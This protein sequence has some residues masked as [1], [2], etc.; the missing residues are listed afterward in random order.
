[1]GHG[2]SCCLDLTTIRRTP[3]RAPGAGAASSDARGLSTASRSSPVSASEPVPIR[4]VRAPDPGTD[5]GARE[6]GS[7]PGRG[8]DV[9]SPGLM[10]RIHRGDRKAMDTLVAEYWDRLVAFTAGMNGSTESAED[11]VQGVFLRIWEGRGEWTPTDRL[12]GLLYRMTRN[13]A[14]NGIRDQ[15]NR[16]RL[17]SG[18]QSWRSRPATPD[19]AL[20]QQ[21]MTMSV[22]M[23]VASLPPRQREVFILARYHGQSYREIADVLEVS[24]QTVANHM[25]AALRAL[26]S[27]LQHLR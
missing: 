15:R 20:D 12:Q 17:L 10:E 3:F 23:A 19:E 14:L 1:M 7:G 6:E 21:D 26:R 16:T 5:L 13:A 4:P 2:V 24:P 25:S 22:E 27:Q 8:G 18:F 9:A 11:L